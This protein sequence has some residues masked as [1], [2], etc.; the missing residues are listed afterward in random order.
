MAAVEGRFVAQLAARISQV[1][2]HTSFEYCPPG[3]RP[4]DRQGTGV[5]CWG[6]KLPVT[7][8]KACLSEPLSATRSVLQDFDPARSLTILSV[9]CNFFRRRAVPV[10]RLLKS[11]FETRLDEICRGKKKTCA[12]SYSARS[13]QGR[14]VQRN[15]R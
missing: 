9:S 1:S 8:H 6:G 2:L 5:P 12:P 15:V 7:L 14:L 3:S 4:G 10:R 11:N 13:A